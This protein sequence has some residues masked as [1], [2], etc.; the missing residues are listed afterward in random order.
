[1]SQPRRKLFSVILF[2]VVGYLLLIYLSA[3]FFIRYT[4]NRYEMRIQGNWYPSRLLPG[5]VQIDQ[6]LIRW[7]N[8]FVVSSGQLN[9]RFRW[10]PLPSSNMFLS[11]SGK[12]LK[13]TLE[14][15]YP[16][17]APARQIDIDQI[18]TEVEFPKSGEP[19]IHVLEIKSPMLRFDLRTK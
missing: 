10:F 8:H 19:I 17:P 1:M 12:N 9:V 18:D 14:K 7:R 15:Q 3:F 2:L 16:I 13:V 6:P 4:E 5:Y 11:I